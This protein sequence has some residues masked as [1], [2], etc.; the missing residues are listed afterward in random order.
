[1]NHLLY[2]LVLFLL[3]HLHSEIRICL[4]NYNF[5]SLKC[6]LELQCLFSLSENDMPFKIP[7][8]ITQKRAIL[9]YGFEKNQFPAAIYYN[10]L[11]IKCTYIFVLIKLFLFSNFKVEAISSVEYNIIIFLHTCITIIWSYKKIYRYSTKEINLKIRPPP[12]SFK[13][14][15]EF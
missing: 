7:T 11:W 14:T 6:I 5:C 4:L 12:Q 10:I 2:L 8:L 15:R 1:M 3:L 13:Y 9:L